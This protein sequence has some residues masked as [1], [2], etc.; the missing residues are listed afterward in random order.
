MLL[1]NDIPMLFAGPSL[2]WKLISFDAGIEPAMR[3][4]SMMRAVV[5]ECRMY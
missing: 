2:I 4:W 1:A 3:R 5:T